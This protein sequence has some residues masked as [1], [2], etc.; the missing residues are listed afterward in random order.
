MKRKEKS[1]KT[2]TREKRPKNKT[3]ENV[4]KKEN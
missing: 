1:K 4:H 2:K 3:E